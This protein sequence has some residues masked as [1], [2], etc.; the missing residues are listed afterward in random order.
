MHGVCA[1][2]LASSAAAGAADTCSGV[3]PP[4]RAERA[5]LGVIGALD[6]TYRTV[7]AVAARLLL[8]ALAIRG[9]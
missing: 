4:A 9:L 8:R 3:A 7:V 5:V 1:V 6:G 2:P